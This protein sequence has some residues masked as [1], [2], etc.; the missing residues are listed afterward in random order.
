MR[1]PSGPTTSTTSPSAASSMPVSGCSASSCS[2]RSCPGSAATCG[3]RCGSVT[4]GHHAR[5]DCLAASRAV[6]RHFSSE[7]A[8]RSPCHCWTQRAAIHGTISSTPTSVASSTASSPRSPLASAWART[9]RGAGASSTD[10][11][12]TARRTRS[13]PRPVTTQVARAPS[14]STTSTTSPVRSRRTVA[15]WWPSGPVSTRCAP[16][17][18]SAKKTGLVTACACRT[19]CRRRARLPWPSHPVGPR[20][21]RWRARR[22]AG[23]AAR[24]AGS[25]R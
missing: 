6:A 20:P 21:G 19:A 16:L 2:T 7:R 14:P 10:R 25:G 13:W 8:P 1:P 11:A 17:T 18:S 15:A 3:S 4:A 22:A 5:R 9:R 24:R 23:A 12:V